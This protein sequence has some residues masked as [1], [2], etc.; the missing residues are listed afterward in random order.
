M[1]RLGKFA[2]VGAIGMTLQLSLLVLFTR[3][4]QL[5]TTISTA[6]AVEITVLHNFAWHQ[7]FTWKDR[8]RS[9]LRSLLRFH[10]GNG[11]VSL[12]GNIFINS[13]LIDHLLVA[14]WLAGVISIASCS[15]VNFAIADSWAFSNRLQAEL[16]DKQALLSINEKQSTQ[17]IGD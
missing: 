8:E 15:I 4:F 5:P 11:A 14:P 3:K 2:L 6:L 17:I 13:I 10:I 9:S 7:R 16:M 1:M 12:L